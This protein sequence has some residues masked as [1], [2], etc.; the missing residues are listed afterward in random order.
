MEEHFNIK[1]T[2]FCEVSQNETA[3]KVR[4]K[5]ILEAFEYIV[6]LAKDSNLTSEF[7]HKASSYIKYASR[8]LKL[9]PL[10]T[11]L[12]AL[13]VDRSE[14]SSIRLSE[15]ASYIGCRTTNVK[16]LFRN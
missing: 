7:C 1:E 2:E 8:K 13:F 11:V 12:L 5:N 3:E 15:I 14:D 16:A 9:P 10:Q 6:D 4:V